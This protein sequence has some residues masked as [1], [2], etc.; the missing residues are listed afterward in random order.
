MAL[1][2]VTGFVPQVTLNAAE[3]RVEAAMGLLNVA[4]A[5]LITA[6]G[7]VLAVGAWR[8]DGIAGPEQWVAWRCGVSPARARRLVA[9]ARALADLPAVAAVFEAGS[10]SEDQVHAV[11]AHTDAA[12]DDQVAQ[13]APNCTVNQLHRALRTIP[14]PPQ[15]D[16]VPAEADPAS[17]RDVLSYGFDD[18]GRCRGRF[19]LCP[20]KGAVL[21]KMLER[22]RADLFDH[23]HTNDRG[24]AVGTETSISW[25]DALIHAAETALRAL[26][27]DASAGR[28]IGERFQAIIYIDADNP[29]DTRL[30][31]G[32]LLSDATRRYLSCDATLRGIIERDGIPIASTEL[33]RTVPPRIRALIEQRDGGCVIPGCDV[34][35]WL[36]I[37]HILHW[38]DGGLT[39]PDNL[40]AVCPAH[41]RM[42]HQA[43]SASAATQPHPAGSPS[44]SPTQTAHRSAAPAPDHPTPH[45][46]SSYAP[47]TGPT[48]AANTSTP[49][50]SPGAKSEGAKALSIRRREGLGSLDCQR[51]VPDGERARTG[52]G[53]QHLETDVVL[54]VA[55]AERGPLAGGGGRDPLG[56]RAQITHRFATAA[57]VD[58]GRVLRRP[59][60]D[61]LGVAGRALESETGAKLHQLHLHSG[62]RFSKNACLASAASS[63]CMRRR[64]YSC[65]IR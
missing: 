32:P 58:V 21:V 51:R 62:S 54:A 17:G 61:D 63:Y 38:G 6:I 65:S 50:P 44:P 8:V 30:H 34:C 45:R 57:E 25:V 1:A 48:P 36:H 19:D 16:P 12:H 40:A 35:R 3:G 49:P 11:C 52:M 14:A 29:A 46:A 31:L 18:D 4:T 22:G 7:E 28:P 43:G 20:D 26:D 37:H 41:H 64:V 47:T 56:R 10:L 55:L 27:A 59:D 24:D 15:A 13:L 5:D 23:R 2:E 42:H 60:D 9:S 39:V 33:A 53:A